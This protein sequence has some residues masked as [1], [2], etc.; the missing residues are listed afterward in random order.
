MSQISHNT[1]YLSL[2]C[3]MRYYLLMFSP[4]KAHF[5]EYSQYYSII[6]LI[7]DS[8]KQARNQGKNSVRGPKSGRSSI[9]FAIQLPRHLTHIFISLRY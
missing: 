2:T 3:K 5:L 7:S 9:H 4:F 8:S 1:T 6:V